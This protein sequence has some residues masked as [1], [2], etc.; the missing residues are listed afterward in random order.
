M[1]YMQV[2]FSTSVGLPVVEKQYAE[3]IGGLAGILINPDN[4]KVEG[5]YVKVPGVFRSS[6]LFLPS[7]DV[8][9]WGTHIS[10]RDREVFAYAEDLIRLKPLLEDGR[11][12]LGQRMQTESGQKLG[13]CADVQFNTKTMRL[14][15][16][17]PRK[18]WRLGIA[19][20]I[21][22]VIEVRKDSII[23]RDPPV[24]KEE[25]VKEVNPV[26]ALGKIQDIAEPGIVR[27]SRSLNNAQK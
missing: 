23:V 24:T 15:W 13:V 21:S 8:I 12:L 22:E 20:P 25:Q 27:P 3:T 26:E 14:T 5:F 4:G 2:R 16:L 10:V 9:K 7:L 17:F 18:W 11:M 1:M 19:V 6:E